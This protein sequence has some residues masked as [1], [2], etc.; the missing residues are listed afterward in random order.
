MAD[1]QLAQP[2]A[3]PDDDDGHS[4]LAREDGM[5][6][7]D[8]VQ[9]PETQYQEVSSFHIVPTKTGDDEAVDETQVDDERPRTA[10]T[11][12]SGTTDFENTKDGAILAALTVP[13]GSKQG[14]LTDT[15]NDIGSWLARS[16]LASE[17]TPNTE[18]SFTKANHKP[19]DFSGN[20]K[21]P[22]AAPA[23]A[24]PET[25]YGPLETGTTPTKGT[26]TA[27]EP[28]QDD[29]QQSLLQ[30]A[31]DNKEKKRKKKKRRRYAT[32]P[33]E[34]TEQYALAEPIEPATA[35]PTIDTID[36][37]NNDDQIDLVDPYGLDQEYQDQPRPVMPTKQIGNEQMEARASSPHTQLHN[38]LQAAAFE[39]DQYPGVVDDV[40][41][42]Q[43]GEWVDQ[44]Q[45]EA[46]EAEPLTPP[47]NRQRL[48]HPQQAGISTTVAQA[49]HPQRASNRPTTNR[50]TKRKSKA[51]RRATAP[52]PAETLH[53][54]QS[55]SDV[56]DYLQILAYKVQQKHQSSSTRLAVEREAMQAELQQIFDSKQSLQEELDA[57]EQQ[58]I[59]LVA[60]VEQQKTKVAAYEAKMNRFKTFVDGLGN[61]VDAL[62]KEAGTTR[63]KGE[64]LAREGDDRKAEQ[65]VLFEQL[66]TCADKSAQLKDQALRACH[67]AQA[68]LQ[69]AHLQNHYLEQQLSERVGLLAEERDR[70]SQLERQL[71]TA[72]SSSDETVVRALK[73]NSDAVLDKLFEIHAA[74]EDAEDG[75]QTTEMIEKALAAVQALTSQHSANADDLASAKNM[76][77]SLSESVNGFFEATNA[78]RDSEHPDAGAIQAHL[79][80]ALKGLRADLSQREDLIRQ[81]AMHREAIHGLQDKLK[82]SSLQATE[83]TSR[84]SATQTQKDLLKEQNASL[85]AKLTA[86]Q[87]KSSPAENAHMHLSEVKAELD[88]KNEALE[89]SRTDLSGKIEELRTLAAANANLQDQMQMLQRRLE[90]VQN[91]VVDLAPER[92][93]L[94]SKFKAQ[95]EKEQ[96]EMADHSRRT[97]IK[98]KMEND[99]K[100]RQATCSKDNLQKQIQPLKEELAGTKAKLEELQGLSSKYT[101]DMEVRFREK[102]GLVL[103]KQQEVETLQASLK[104]LEVHL[105]GD[106]SLK[107]QY[108]ALSTQHHALSTKVSAEKAKYQELVRERATVA[109]QAED[110]QHALEESQS[111]EEEAKAELEKHRAESVTALEDVE[112][113]LTEA[114]EVADRAEAG[115]EHYKQSC[116][117]AIA[118]AE[119]Q[120]EKNLEALQESL[121]EA[122]AALEKQEVSS[123]KFRAE[124][125]EAWRLEQEETRDA[126]TKAKTDVA[127]AQTQRDEALAESERLRTELAN[128]ASKQAEAL[129]PQL[130]QHHVQQQPSSK[131]STVSATRPRVP[132]LREGITPTASNKENE[133]PKP[134]KKVDRNANAIMETGPVPVPEVLR[135]PESR[136]KDVAQNQANARGPV[137][138]ESQPRGITPAPYT[139]IGDDHRKESHKP[140]LFGMFSDSDDMLDAASMRPKLAQMVEET[141]FDDRF[142]S[143]AAFNNSMTSSHAARSKPP[144][145]VFSVPSLCGAGHKAHTVH[146]STTSEEQRK[147]HD[148]EAAQKA[149]NEFVVYDDS[150]QLNDSSSTHH[151]EAR[152]VLQDSLSLSQADKDKYT[153]RKTYPVPNSASKMVH[154]E[155]QD[156][157]GTKRRRSDRSNTATSRGDA[158]YTPKIRGEGRDAASSMQ[159]PNAAQKPAMHSSSPDFIHTAASARK[160]N[161]YHTP[162]GSGSAKRRLSRTNSGPTADPRLARREAPAAPKRKAENY[163]VEGY[164]HERKKRLTK[165]S[166]AAPA[167]ASRYS[168]R[169]STHQPS[170]SDL[171]SMP[172]MSGRSGSS[173]PHAAGPNSRMLTLAG[174][175]SR[176]S[177]GHKKM[178]KTKE[179]SA[180]F[181][182]EL[183]R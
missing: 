42:F 48:G 163:I 169:A 27:A 177:Q 80:D 36:G 22:V 87:T 96:R 49:D 83:A 39:H 58:K 126:S 156:A 127:E 165:G 11:S 114:K 147:N 59:S 142:P 37:A 21:G 68:E 107:S 159:P 140:T 180:R 25:A 116:K 54:D 106:A 135:R 67:D 5:E 79:D 43:S 81:D 20:R 182:Q 71:A 91:Q 115:V 102:Q 144:S 99:N 82:A 65:T 63:R 121:K 52:A 101:N 124:I 75:K 14:S 173:Q 8:F 17:V 146:Q 130:Q 66:S 149:F 131:G 104:E 160:T 166:T 150:Q 28:D 98:D 4:A 113:Q 112:H 84:L 15:S 105:K 24:A 164:E 53:S 176:G 18:F 1:T 26:L 29:I 110:T 123:K 119:K 10:G 108:D 109:K 94:E 60:V 55:T 167:D 134:R 151:R 35:P 97:Y 85:Q 100:L 132:M 73:S 118:K 148:A 154:R 13:H 136:A 23:T 88:V 120:G 47:R 50:V 93:E 92:A 175:S 179:Y 56:N 78:T 111:A 153:F 162:V 38:D 168:L 152:L 31:G 19:L 3:D 16:A 76:I 51:G 77:E 172:S 95:L 34:P 145:S 69:A 2:V 72:A 86:L 171:P 141:Q 129:R 117:D 74:I 178:S 9:V 6:L 174:G 57:V 62:K 157:Q 45:P 170:I 30:H 122:K 41:A 89:S 103:A 155:E 46:P 33:T 139:G 158:V 181:A 70:R 143:F 7:S 138:E 161:T 133:P 12:H 125:D 44:A 183:S 137:V 64:Q 61:D 32:A 128:M 40:Q 90:E